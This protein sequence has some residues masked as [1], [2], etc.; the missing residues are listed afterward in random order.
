MHLISVLGPLPI[1]GDDRWAEVTR[2]WL[3]N[4]L[5]EVADEVRRQGIEVTTALRFGDVVGSLRLETDQEGV[6]LIVTSTHGRG[7]FA[8]AWIG[9]VADALTRHATTPLILVHPPKS[10]DH[11]AVVSSPRTILVPL[12]GSELSESAL[13]KAIELGQLFGAAYHLSRIVP[14]P[15]DIRSDVV[16]FTVQLDEGVLRAAKLAAAEYLE[17]HAGHLRWRGLLVT[18]SVAVDARPGRG[19]LSEAAAVGCDMI[20]MSTHARTGLRRVVL[21]SAADEVL[22]HTHLPLM[23]HRPAKVA[24]VVL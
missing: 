4:R 18:T 6:D 13:E 8:R 24:A 3:T 22:R 5:A 21:G 11:A 14:F 16:P 20:V 9:S 12:D 10:I 2:E 15:I 7:A 17:V 1:N 23:L 19:I